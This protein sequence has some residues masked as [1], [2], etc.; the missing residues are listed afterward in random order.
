MNCTRDIMLTAEYY[1]KQLAG[2]PVQYAGADVEHPAGSLNPPKRKAAIVF[3]ETNGDPT[4]ADSANLFIKLVT[5]GMCGSPADSVKAFPYA[6]DITTAEQQSTTTVAGL[7]SSGVTTVVFFGDPIAPVFLSNTADSQDYHPEII[8]T[9]VGLVDY[10]VLGQLYNRN[11]WQHAFGISTLADNIPFTDSDAVKAWQDAGAAG[12][13]DTTENLAWTYF[14]AMATAF[15]L[16][17]PEPTPASIRQGLFN[18][19]PAGGDHL[20]PTQEYG[21]PSDYTGL[22]DARVVYWC[23]GVNSPINGKPGS[24]VSVF[25]GHRY[26]NGQI[27]SAPI[28]VFPHGTC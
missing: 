3:P 28:P 10:D 23:A 9:G 22:R 6:S 2:K 1:C 16:A 20:H 24:Y 7:K 5:G 27:P 14:T 13:P 26:Q 21:R 4:Y 18:A 25:A 12:L 11:V 19:A 17:G 15:Q 8:M